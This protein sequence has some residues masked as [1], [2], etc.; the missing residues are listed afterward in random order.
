[1][2]VDGNNVDAVGYP[3]TG[4]DHTEGDYLDLQ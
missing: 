3:V 4:W 2:V 1:L